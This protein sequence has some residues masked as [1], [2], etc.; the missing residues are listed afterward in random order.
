[1]PT[2][3]LKTVPGERTGSS[4]TSLPAP[5]ST[6][7]AGAA[8]PMASVSSWSPSATVSAPSGH[9]AVTVPGA[10]HSLTAVTAG[11]TGTIATASPSRTL[12]AS[13]ETVRWFTSPAPA[14][15][16]TPPGGAAASCSLETL[17]APAG[18]AHATAAAHAASPPRSSGLQ[19]ARFGPRTAIPPDVIAP[20]PWQSDGISRA[21]PAQER[22]AQALCAVNRTC[23]N[24]GWQ[25]A[26]P[27]LRKKGDVSR[28][29]CDSTPA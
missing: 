19:P 3:P 10:T 17:A 6:A 21:T 9:L 14:A 11:T 23:A 25:L 29:P 8:G 24:A 5:P 27:D 28:P 4:T 26:C 15:Y 2:S 1:M 12:A 20:H 7:I 16:V 18:A 13:P 22:F